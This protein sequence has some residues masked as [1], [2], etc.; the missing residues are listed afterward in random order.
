MENQQDASPQDKALK[1]LFETEIKAKRIRR[2]LNLH[3]PNEVLGVWLEPDGST[4]DLIADGYGKFML[5]FYDLE[6]REEWETRWSEAHKEHP[7]KGPMAEE[8]TKML[9]EDGRIEEIDN[10]DNAIE[11]ARE[12]SD[13]ESF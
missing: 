4:I 11:L 5:R 13:T 12:F 2:E 1:E 3:E 8:F 10:L 9:K 7:G 6:E